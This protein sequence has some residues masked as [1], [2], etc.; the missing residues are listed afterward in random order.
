VL[1]P[2]LIEVYAAHLARANPIY[3]PPT[4]RILERCLADERRHLGEATPVLAALAD[5]D[6]RRA[7]AAAWGAELRGLLEAAGGVAGGPP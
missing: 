4:R 7:R 3:E 2:H 6:A 5:T 1:K